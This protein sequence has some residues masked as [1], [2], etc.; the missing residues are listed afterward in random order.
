MNEEQIRLEEDREKK[1]HWRRWGPYLSNR[2]WGTV[3]EDYSADG[4][5]WKYFPFDQAASRA[6]RWGEDGILG[7]SDN[8]QKICFAFTFWNGKDP[9]LKERFFGLNNEEGNHGEDVKEYYYYLDNTPT[10]SYMSA[11]YKYPQEAYP[12][13]ALKNHGRGKNEPELELMDTGVFDEDRY[14]DLFVEYAKVSP[15]D[16]VICLKAFNRSNQL[17][18]LHV[19]PTFWLRTCWSWKGKEKPALIE[20]KKNQL[21]LNHP[22]LGTRRLYYEGIPKPLFCENESNLEKLFGTPNGSPYVKDAFQE[23]LIAGNKNAVNPDQKGTKAALHYILEI[24]PNGSLEIRLRLTNEEMVAPFADFESCFAK[25]KAEADLFYAEL[26]GEKELN[27]EKKAIQRQAL[28]GLLWSKQYYNYVVEEWL[29]GDDPENP[30]PESHKKIRNFRWRHVYSDD[31][32][33]MPDNWEYPWFASWDLGFHCLT[34]SLVDPD[35][36]KRQLTLLTREWY[37]HPNGQIPAYEWDFEDVNPPV[38]AWASWRV[39]KIEQRKHGR[40]DRAFLESIFQKLLLNFTW[41]VNRKD[42]DDRNVFE[43]GFLGLDNI[44]IFNRSEQLPKGTKLTQSDATSWMAMFC[45]NMWTIAIELSLTEPGYEDMASKFFEHFL[46]I[47]DAINFQHPDSPPLWDEEDSFYYDLLQKKDGT[48]DYLKVRSMVGLIPLFAVATLSE[49]QLNQLPEFKKRFDWF[50]A[51]RTDLC[52]KVACMETLG[53]KERR[54]LAILDQDRMRKVLVKMLDEK[55]FLSPYGIRSLSK[56]HKNH[57]FVLKCD[58]IINRI[59]YAPAESKSDLYGGNSNWRG[60]VWFPLNYL[61]IEALQKFHYYSGDAFTVECPTG[62]G[63][64]MTLKEV[65]EEISRRLVRLFEKDSNG[66]R[67]FQGKVEKFQRDPHFQDYFLF[68]EYFHGDNG[69]GLGASHQTGWTALV[70]KLLQ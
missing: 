23:C 64:Q 46:F 36:A 55:E 40:E 11:L 33:S 14:Y 43:G 31:V 39:Y 30:P 28:A 8:H 10:H 42:K 58:G 68:Y 17:G 41:W 51:H 63:V 61:L 67:P 48:W 49:E 20:A 27:E 2:Q 53:Q 25:R 13:E 9:I 47:A 5:P 19:L 57:P 16:L 37:M 7:I 70:A 29:N 6:Y 4:D 66:M 15:E 24:P 38:L 32:L 22:G 65:A 50:L 35:F 21:F 59:D 26:E 62:S 3:R 34:M 56:F 18:R 45:L 52:T 1:Q 69:A 44:S 54:L 12:Y 60:P